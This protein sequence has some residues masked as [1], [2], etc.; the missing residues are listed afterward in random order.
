ML[1]TL[2]PVSQLWKLSAGWV[3]RLASQAW[4]SEPHCTLLLSVAGRPS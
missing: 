4:M 2:A 3:T 1:L